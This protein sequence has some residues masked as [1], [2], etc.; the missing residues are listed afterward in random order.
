M[1]SDR[2]AKCLA[3]D[4]KAL[5][6]ALLKVCSPESL[7]PVDS[8]VSEYLVIAA[9]HTSFLQVLFSLMGHLF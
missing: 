8:A 6:K 3:V 7:I 2:E 5:L 1:L 4:P 9:D